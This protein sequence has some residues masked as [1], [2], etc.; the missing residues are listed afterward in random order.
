MVL[1][2]ASAFTGRV[3]DQA[4]VDAGLVLRAESLGVREL[5]LEGL[6]SEFGDD[7]VRDKLQQLE[8]RAANR[9]LPPV[10]NAYS[11]LRSLLRNADAS[12]EPAEAPRT[13]VSA[14]A[15]PPAPVSAAR[16]PTAARKAAATSI[17]WPCST[18]SARVPRGLPCRTWT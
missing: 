15:A 18:I 8:R 12:D 16:R 14:D 5:K 7:N 10:D 17:S 13:D 1:W 11:Y 2:G 4:P 6:I 9:Q 3:Q